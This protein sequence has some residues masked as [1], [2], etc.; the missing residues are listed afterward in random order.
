MPLRARPTAWLMG[1][2]D[3]DNG[4]TSAVMPFR[5]VFNSPCTPV[6]GAGRQSPM[7]EAAMQHTAKRERPRK[8]PRRVSLSR[9]ERLQPDAAVIL[10][11][12]AMSST[13]TSTAL[14]AFDRRLA[15]RVGTA[16]ALT[17]T[18]RKLAVL[19]YR[20][21]AGKLVYHDPGATAYH[22]LNRTREL[23]LLRK[24][25]KLL[26]L[27]LLDPSTGEVLLSANPVS[28]SKLDD[29]A[30]RAPG[31]KRQPSTRHKQK[32]L[33]FAQQF[34]SFLR[35]GR[36]SCATSLPTALPWAGMLRAFGADDN[37]S[38]RSLISM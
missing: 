1:C 6:F 17:A 13:R 33:E 15:L 16:K 22:Q 9:W 12:C 19:V 25:A 7:E 8:R 35:G 38:R 14:G 4:D 10:R 32:D 2:G 5:R 30:R 3:N 27:E 11:R 36:R 23:K 28:R 26:G 18:A 31:Q 34:R 24:R 21:L 29:R 37:A 20:V